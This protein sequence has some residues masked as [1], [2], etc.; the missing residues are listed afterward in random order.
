MSIK[1]YVHHT[2]IYNGKK[3]EEAQVSNTSGMIKIGTSV[4]LMFL[5]LHLQKIF[6]NSGKAPSYMMFLKKIHKAV[7]IVRT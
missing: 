5:E 2:V 1:T 7:Y 6:N 3:L 4:Q